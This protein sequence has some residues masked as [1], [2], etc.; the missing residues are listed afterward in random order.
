M[1]EREDELAW[2]ERML[3]EKEHELKKIEEIY[4]ASHAHETTN[5]LLLT[6]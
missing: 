5:L 4:N 3:N 6:S 2:H 1:T